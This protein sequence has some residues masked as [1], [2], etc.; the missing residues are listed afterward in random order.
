MELTGRED[1]LMKLLAVCNILCLGLYAL[2]IFFYGT[3]GAAVA[4]TTLRVTVHLI[5]ARHIIRSVGV[6]PTILSMFGTRK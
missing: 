4:A 6:D 3:L 1:Y 2:L 5:L